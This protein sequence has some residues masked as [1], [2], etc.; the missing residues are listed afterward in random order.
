[1]KKLLIGITFIFLSLYI[2]GCGM[3]YD[4]G[5]IC[6]EI[7]NINIEDYY[8]RDVV[9]AEG[10]IT[11]VGSNGES[12]NS[13]NEITITIQSEEPDVDA[14][15]LINN[16][17]ELVGGD[18]KVYVY[19]N[20]EDASGV[21][22]LYEAQGEMDMYCVVYFDE[23]VY[24]VI[25]NNTTLNIQFTHD[26]IHD[27][28]VRT[29]SRKEIK[30]GNENIVELLADIYRQEGRAN[31][32][33]N[34]PRLQ[35]KYIAEYERIYDEKYH[36]QFT[37][38]DEQQRICQKIKWESVSELFPQFMDLNGDGFLDMRVVVDETPSYD[39]LA[40][41]TWNQEKECFEKVMYDGILS[42]IESQEGKLY[43]W[44]RSGNGYILEV[45]QWKGNVLIKESE[46]KIEPDDTLL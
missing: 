36:I 28:L 40:L 11:Y 37:L 15:Q 10:K 34:T 8:V 24:S 44:V 6:Y 30:C 31:Y 33:F 32:Q 5:K 17:F 1:M 21:K 14:L 45:L 25:I 26:R 12:R 29:V 35:R 46:S 27:Y 2:V 16:H 13:I 22:V 38:Y 20:I 43:N 41:Y 4:E 7:L 42:H 39:I 23:E 18:Y 19:D 3:E 9:E